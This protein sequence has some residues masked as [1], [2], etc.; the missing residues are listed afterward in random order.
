MGASMGMDRQMERVMAALRKAGYDPVSQLVG[1]Y[2][3]GDPSYITRTDGARG[4]LLAL[5][6]EK[7]REYIERLQKPQ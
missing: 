4:L 5:D 1:Y 7:V 2:R 3:T 6:Q